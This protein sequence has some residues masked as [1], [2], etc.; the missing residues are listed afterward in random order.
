MKTGNTETE[1]LQKFLAD[2]RLNRSRVREEIL[3]VFLRA[4]RHLT[5]DQ[6]YQ[7]ARRRLPSVGYATVYR[8]L[9]IFCDCGLCRPIKLEN[10]PVR[11]EH[12]YRHDH[13]DHLVCTRCGRLVEVFDPTLEQLQEKLGR[14]HGFQMERHRL[15]LYGIC[16]ECRKK[17]GPDDRN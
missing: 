17:G 11:Y 2:R 16:P 8:S 1:V 10:E 3:D 7:L 13:H 4:E 15:E 5:A 9:K 6:L 12:L 14:K